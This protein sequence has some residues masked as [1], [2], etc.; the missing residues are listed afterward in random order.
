[1]PAAHQIAEGVA[2]RV[3]TVGAAALGDELFLLD[4]QL[5]TAGLLRQHLDAAGALELDREENCLFDGAAG[6]DDAVIA[7]DHHAA[8]AERLG[9][10]LAARLIDDEIGGLGEDRHAGGEHG[11]VIAH[12]AELFAE[13]GERDGIFR[14]GVDH[15]IDVRARP[16]HLGVDED[17]VVARP[18]AGDLVALDVHRD[19]VVVGHLF[20]AD[21]AGLHQEFVGIV[22]QPRRDVAPDVV[23]LAFV[24]QNAAAV[25][26]LFAQFV[27]HGFLPSFCCCTW[28]RCPRMTSISA[29]ASAGCRSARQAT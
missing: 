29:P 9:D 26:Q 10:G 2:L 23:A 20:D 27:G 3:A 5:G 1:M 14:M 18:V 8:L 4:E 15:A 22:G 25:D 17:L 16:H 28:F 24:D 11:A 13:R 6:G 12:R 19:D 21:A 7:Q